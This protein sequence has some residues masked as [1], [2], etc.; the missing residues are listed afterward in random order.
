[1]NG[2]DVEVLALCS[3]SDHFRILVGQKRRG[4]QAELRS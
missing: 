4:T 2:S 1:M 3:E